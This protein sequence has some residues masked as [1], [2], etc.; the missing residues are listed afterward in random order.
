MD[1]EQD[2]TETQGRLN[3]VVAK[4]GDID[5]QVS[6]LQNERQQLLQEALR[7]DGELR[8]LKRHTNG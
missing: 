8:G 1:I 5:R 4:I 6:T 7:L 2:I 3:D